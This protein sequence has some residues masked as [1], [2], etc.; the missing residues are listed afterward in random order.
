MKTAS[1]RKITV[2]LGM[3]RSGTSAIAKAMEVFGVSLGNNLIPAGFDNEKGFFEDRDITSFNDHLQ[4]ML[5]YQWYGPE[6]VEPFDWQREDVQTK[7]EE[8]KSL[9]EEKLSNNGNFGFKD[10]RTAVLLEFWNRVFDELGVTPRY[11]IAV[12][13]PIDV[14]SSLHARND[15]AIAKSLY[16]WA[17]SNI[18]S[19]ELTSG[20]SRVIVS[21]EALL[22]N[23]EKQLK[24]IEQSLDLPLPEDSHRLTSYID[25]FLDAKLR[26]QQ[27]S[28]RKMSKALNSYSGLHKL[29]KLTD[30]LAHDDEVLGSESF[31]KR[32]K[33]ITSER[34][35]VLPLLALYAEAEADLVKAQKFSS[36][37]T[38]ETQQLTTHNLALLASNSDHEAEIQKLA[39]L[40]QGLLTSNSDHEVEIQKLADL[41]LELENSIHQRDIELQQLSNYI[42]ALKAAIEQ[43]DLASDKLNEYRLHNYSLM[44]EREQLRGTTASLSEDVYNLR[45]SYSWKITSP[46]RA[47]LDLTKLP[48]RNHKFALP[49]LETIWGHVP[50][51]SKNKYAAKKIVFTLFRFPLMYTR[52][53][54]DWAEYEG[55]RIR[56]GA[57]AVAEADQTPFDRELDGRSYVEIC[58]E[59]NPILL[60]VKLIAFYLPQY[61]AIPENDRWWGK[62]FTEWTNV[63]PAKPQYEGHY[64]PHIPGE[65][66]YYDLSDITVQKRQ[67][68][69]AQ[70]YGLGGFCFYFYWFAGQRLLEAPTLQYLENPDLS[71]PFCLCWANENWSRTWDGLENELLISQNHSPEDDLAFIEYTSRYFKD[72]RYIRINERPVLMIYRP[73]LLP[74]PKATA[75]RWRRWCSENGIGEIYL[76]TTHS[77]DAVDPAI[78]GFDAAVEFPPN[79]TAPTVVTDLAPQ[80][81]NDFEGIVYDWNSIAERSQNY[82]QQP[83]RLFRSVNPSWDNT[84]R[85]KNGGAIFAGSNPDTYQAWLEN[86]AENTISHTNNQDERL[87][88]VNAW[89]EWAEGAHLEPDEAYGYAYL[90]ATRN[91]LENANKAL[92]ADERQILLVAHDAHP[93]GAQSLI[94]HMAKFLRENFGFQIDMVVLGDGP[95]LVEYAKYTTLHSLAGLNHRGEE[96]RKLVEKLRDAG[97]STALCNTTVTGLFA[98]TLKGAGFHVVTL[99]HELPDVIRANKLEKHV[100]AIADHSDTIVFPADIV[101]DGFGQ[102]ATLD[103]VK[104]AL[105]PQGVFK[106]NQYRSTQQRELAHR[107]LRSRLNLPDNQKVIL[108]VGYA[109]H[110]K[111]IDLFVEVGLALLKTRSDVTFVWVGHFDTSIEQKIRATVKNSGLDSHFVFPGLDFET[112]AY[113]AGADIYALTSREDPFPSVILQAL[114]VATPVVAFDGAGGFTDILKQGCGLLAKPLDTSDFSELLNSLLENKQK[115][116]DIGSCGADLIKTHYSFNRYL[117]DLLDMCNLEFKRISVVIPNYN[118]ASYFDSRLSSILDQSYP[119]FEVIVLDDCSSDNSIEVIEN[120]LSFCSVDNQFIVNSKN[121]GSPFHQWKV[122]VDQAEGDYVWLAE[123][124]DLAEPTFLEVIARGFSD[125]NVGLSYCESKQIDENGIIISESYND[126]VSDISMQKWKESHIASGEH[127]VSEALAVKN[128]IPNVSGVVFRKKAIH[129]ALTD[130]T[131]VILKFKYAG[132]WLLYSKILANWKIAFSNERLNLHRRHGKGLTISNFSS[133]QLVEILKIQQWIAHSYPVSSLTRKIALEYAQKIYTDFKLD[134]RYTKIQENPEMKP[135]LE[136]SLINETL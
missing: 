86:A 82:F 125:P 133:E 29:Y 60:P 127:E 90:Q 119:I 72:E 87:V 66:G 117:F 129:K 101:R 124:D 25:D 44:A 123:A 131:E 12:R 53:Y 130:H 19:L 27:T 106:R 4:E 93:H 24:R 88:F 37:K 9:L 74:D 62:G 110:R 41:N 3:H 7:K 8:A 68:E 70:L 22:M 48:T 94:H 42:D 115:L 80:A 78:Y 69:L 10:P 54:R 76:V 5:G 34:S 45:A 14:A 56:A 116:A 43:K 57:T 121:S 89:N 40:N 50:L 52:I 30:E 77:F 58:T 46:L 65:L 81:N 55:A 13:N 17:A 136:P 79:N 84:A 16:L 51:S 122:G 36:Q 33:S 118:Y 91:A 75:A 126:Y 49:S 100:Q 15:L 92:D 104:T 26:H 132:D 105:R 95:L 32:L 31:A 97:H 103:Q 11:V 2:I 20:F 102:F 21:F 67:V 39:D 114:E 85:R 63:K 35:K 134:K 109:D 1:D 28:S 108:A 59:P 61:H 112:D 64:Q 135:Y 128:T 47:L 120:R 111:G 113:F 23:P 71:L 38:D 6:I 96:A 83:Y 99:I 18:A 73:G 107:R 98:E